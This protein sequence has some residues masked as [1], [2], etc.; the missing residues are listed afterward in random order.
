MQFYNTNSLH[1]LATWAGP[2]FY[3]RGA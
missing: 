2:A 3:V 1:M